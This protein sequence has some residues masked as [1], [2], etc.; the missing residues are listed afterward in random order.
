MNFNLIQNKKIMKNMTKLK[1]FFLIVCIAI[2]SSADAQNQI[3]S[4]IRKNSISANILG[5]GTYLGISYERLFFDRVS[6]EISIGMMAFGFGATVYPLKKVKKA[7]LNPF[8]GLKYTNHAFLDGEHKS[9]TYIPIGLTYFSKNRLNFSIEIGP[10]YFD[11]KSPGFLPTQEELDT[12][13]YSDFG[14]WGN[15]KIGF[16]L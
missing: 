1:L 16:R 12:Y 11:H 15:L 6:S 4:S 14:I 8:I 9:A 5:T 13:P 10:S 7:Q 3:E 2:F